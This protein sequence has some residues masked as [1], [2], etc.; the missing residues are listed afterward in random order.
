M[1][2][3]THTLAG[4]ALAKA[5]LGRLTPLATAT[6]VL[7][8]NA[9][10]VDV[11]AYLR[12]EYFGLAFRRGI[13]HGVPA[14]VTLPLAVAGAILAWDRGV[15]LRR[16]PGADAARPLTVFL[17]ALLG[18]ATHPLLDWTNNYGMRWWL[19]FDGRWSYGDGLFIIDPWLWLT[20]GAAVYLAEPW[21]RTAH[22]L[23]GAMAGAA[24]L[25]MLAGP[26][27]SAARWA[28]TV[29]VSLVVGGRL[30]GSPRSP[31]AGSRLAV[32]LTT[33]AAI[34]TAGMVLSRER[35]EREVAVVA[36][37][38]GIVP[39]DAVMVAPVPADPFGSTVL[40]RSGDRFVRGTY[41]WLGRPRVRLDTAE[42]FPMRS[43]EA[44]VAAR[45]M[46]AAIAAA[47]EHVEAVRYL[48]WS[49]FP[50]YRVSAE[51]D[52]YRVRISDARYDVRS[53]SLAGLEVVIPRVEVRP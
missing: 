23:W 14:S 44:G 33:L 21:G 13:T 31:A 41:R 26:V 40:V 4:A 53:G 25:V 15:R 24:S 11:L 7:A 20:L 38:A 22:A 8:A 39:V 42:A 52:G 32:G 50:F 36:A 35:A 29:G 12:G 46:E 18:V 19:P 10:D 30:A 49:R 2:N 47:R 1:D 45:E 27:P 37:D 5:G 28:W 51:A 16:E 9:P 3:L 48:T 34:Y 17:L 43:A 6:L